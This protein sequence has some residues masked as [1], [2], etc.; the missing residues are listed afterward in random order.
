MFRDVPGCS[1]MFPNSV[2]GLIGLHMAPNQDPTACLCR[3]FPGDATNGLGW[4]PG[5][6][7]FWAPG[8]WALGP[9]ALGPWAHGPWAQGPDFVKDPKRP[10]PRTQSVHRRGPNN[11]IPLQSTAYFSFKGV[12]RQPYF[13]SKEPSLVSASAGD[14]VIFGWQCQALGTVLAWNML[15]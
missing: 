15:A 5:E 6:I 4:A 7:N 2:L 11:P 14:M 8:P 1:R 10:P 13:P 12:N 9:W 3:D